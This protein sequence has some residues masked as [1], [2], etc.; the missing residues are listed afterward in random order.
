MDCSPSDSS[1]SRFSKDWT[2]CKGACACCWAVLSLGTLDKDSAIAAWRGAMLSHILFKAEELAK[3]DDVLVVNELFEEV[4]E[5]TLDASRP[6]FITEYPAALSPL[7]R[8]SR[9]NPTVA[10]RADLFIAHMELA[11]HYTELNDPI[12]QEQTFSQQL[13]GL[14]EEDSMAK[15]D[16][17][18]IRAQ[19]HGMPPAGGLGIGIDRLVM[20]LTNSQT[21]RDVILFPLL[22]QEK[23]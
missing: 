6:T 13:A 7:T 11:P 16:H 5:K 20:L 14:P 12:M 19:R 22:R 2:S 10:E 21:I 23:S 8:P 17:D 18:F 15:M 4:A 3:V 9:D 1:R